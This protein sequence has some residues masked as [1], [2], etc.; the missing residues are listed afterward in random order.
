MTDNNSDLFEH[1][2][3]IASRGQLP[4]RVDKFIM[5]F[6]ENASRNK[7]Q[8]AIES[9]NVLV[10]G[11]AV[12]SNYKIISYKSASKDFNSFLDLP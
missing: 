8:K 1:F 7:V 5:N 4:L 2:E 11:D 3:F 10:N 9:S 12:K 6:I